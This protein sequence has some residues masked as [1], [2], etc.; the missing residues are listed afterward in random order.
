MVNPGGLPARYVS[1]LENGVFDFD[2]YNVDS[3][4]TYTHLYHQLVSGGALTLLNDNTDTDNI[5]SCT[6]ENF[7]LFNA[8]YFDGSEELFYYNLD[9]LVKIDLPERDSADRYELTKFG[10]EGCMIE[11]QTDDVDSSV[12]TYTFIDGALL[13]VTH[14]RWRNFDTDDNKDYQDKELISYVANIEDESIKRLWGLT[15]EKREILNCNTDLKFFQDEFGFPMIGS[16][17]SAKEIFFG[18]SFSNSAN[19]FFDFENSFELLPGAEI[20]SNSGGVTISISGCNRGI[21]RY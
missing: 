7:V 19:Q 1:L 8:R 16:S 15:Y 10:A 4:A 17:I 18:T 5:I 9:T 11:K 3:S 12:F 20:E 2:Y 21:S 6:S 14:P 13:D